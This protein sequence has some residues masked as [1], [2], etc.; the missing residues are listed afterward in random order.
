[1]NLQV[2][3]TNYDTIFIGLF[4]EGTTDLRFLKNVVKK[5]FVDIGFMECSSEMEFDIKEVRIDKSGLDFNTQV[6]NAS[7]YGV[8]NYGISILCVHSDAD[9]P[10]KILANQK[11][12]RAL[13]NLKNSQEECCEIITP[14]IPVRMTEAWMI[15]DKDL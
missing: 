12:S 1:M 8:D 11:V 14:I 7:R 6:L 4:T 2:L 10:N 15:A 13:E 3:L 9:S 5:A